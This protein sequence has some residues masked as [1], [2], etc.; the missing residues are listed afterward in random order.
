MSTRSRLH[1]LNILGIFVILGLTC[2][3]AHA[4][5]K[6]AAIDAAGRKLAGSVSQEWIFQQILMKLGA[7]DE[8]TQGEARRFYANHQL[9]IE[10]CES[11]HLTKTTHSWSITQEG[12][13]DLVVTIDSER[14]YLLF[15]DDGKK[16]LM[17][18]Q[19]RSTSKTEPTREWEFRLSE[20]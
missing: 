16:H 20:D 9:V 10:K 2:Y 3:P 17:R 6:S 4:E 1:K 5:D 19:S 8:C 14:F 7:S 12:P 15:R 11:G 13:L 18:L